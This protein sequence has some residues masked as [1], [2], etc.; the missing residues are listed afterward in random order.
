MTPTRAPRCSVVIPVHNRASLTRQ[1][2]NTLFG[3]APPA[4][5]FDVIV[6]DDGSTDG[7][8]ELLRRYSRVRTI[9]HDQPRGFARAVNAGAAKGSS[10]YL[11]FLNNDTIPEHGWLDALVAYADG[12]ERVAVVGSKLLYPNDTIQH[13]G[14]VIT[15][16]RLPRHIYLGFPGDHPA[17]EKSRQFRAVTAACALYRRDVFES[18]DGFDEAFAN[19]YEDVDLCLRIG[20]RGHDIHYCHESVLVHLEKATRGV[21]PS[22]EGHDLF[23]KRWP[24][25]KPDDLGYY[26]A[27]GLIGV[28]YKDH[29]PLEL[30]VS[31]LLAVVNPGKEAHEADR[32]LN[33]RARQVFG[34]M[35]ENTRLKLGESADAQ[36][37]TPRDTPRLLKAVLFLS[38]SPGDTMR[39]RCDHQAE[40]LQMLGAS[41]DSRRLSE[42]GLDEVLDRYEIFVLHRVAFGS[43]LRWFLQQAKLRGKIVLFD[44]DDL[45]FDPNVMRHVAAVEDMAEPERTLYE[46]GLARYAAT[47][48]RC[49]GVLVTTEPLRE[50]ASTLHDRVFVVPNAVSSEMVEGAN[51]A[52]TQPGR[53]A[54][55]GVVIGYL[56][57]TK[58]HDRDFLEAADAVLGRLEKDPTARFLVVGHLKL[59]ER[60]D[61]FGDRVERLPIQRWQ[62]LPSILSRIDINLAPLEPDNPFTESKSCVKYLEAGLAGVPTVASAKADFLRVIKP[63]RNGLIADSPSG[64]ATALS[65]LVTSRTRRIAIGEQARSDVR[66]EHTTV[67]RAPLLRDTLRRLVPESLGERR[68]RINWVLLAPIAQTSGGYRN[69]FRIAEYLGERGHDVHA[70]V[71]PVAHLDGLDRDEI[72]SFVESSFD[73]RT[74]GVEV[75]DSAEAP[76]QLRPA[77]VSLATFWTTAYDVAAD[78]VS[79]F[80][81][82]YIQDFE[83]DFYEPTDPAWEEAMETYS[84]PLRQICLGKSLANTIHRAGGRPTSHID[85]AL[86]PEFRVNR[87]PRERGRRPSVLFFAR[88][89]LKRRGY[90]LGIAALALLKD[91]CPDVDIRFFGSAEE[92]LGLVPF[93]FRNLGVLTPAGAAGAMNDAQV[94]LTFSL[95]NI[96]NVAFEGM[97]CGCA[98][99]EADLPQV[100]EMVSAGSD[101]LL[102]PTTPEGVADA[103]ARVTGDPELRIRL[104]CRGAEEMSTRDWAR[105]ASQLEALLLETCFT[106]LNRRV[107]RP[108]AGTVAAR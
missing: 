85:F 58:T 53:Q 84:L 28:V 62:D 5:A 71:A 100:R 4:A 86:D 91:R 47:L 19:G 15:Q 3:D 88:P 50:L 104:A 36:A 92:E 108:P 44:T 41:A 55:E 102:A 32:L 78:P 7:T 16:E 65:E 33:L 73:L 66:R 38:G 40:A 45:V 20:G 51:A 76:R 107:A 83:P 60:F 2:L 35:Q 10:E 70:Y 63:G 105:S 42:V 21:R 64:W 90:R 39:Y 80:K 48:R 29:Y 68:L 89:S 98:V 52:V 97:A 46:Q 12:N 22:D 9:R 67:A 17:T 59:D 23:V 101:C 14:I 106:R 96:S 95:S 8:S 49:D 26:L 31:P 24:D 94:L 79:L 75:N 11:L 6:V 43:D 99:V 103:L 13:A 87:H 34:L 25:L 93:E 77:D 56:S 69:I 61:R 74:V 72:V 54:D 82:Y 30:D 1:C 37:A 81:A 57:G 18:C 27:D